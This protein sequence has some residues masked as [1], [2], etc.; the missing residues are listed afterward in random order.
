MPQVPITMPQLGESMAEAT[1]V[2]IKV[3][4]GDK[5][6]ADQEIIEVETDKA[7]MGVTTPCAGEISKIEAEVKKVYPVGA[8]L[9]YVEASEAD[10][11]RFKKAEPPQGDVAQEVPGRE[12]E[13]TKAGV[14]A[15]GSHFQIDEKELAAVPTGSHFQ[16]D[17]AGVLPVP[18]GAKGA[19]Y[20]SPRVR[21]RM[22]ELGLTN[23]DL[24]S[25]AGSGNAGRV[26]I[27]DL[28]SFLG[29]LE[30]QKVEEASAI[31]TGVANAMRRSWS[32]PLSTIG[33]SVCLDPVLEDR[34][35][36]DPKPGPALY[37]A[38][39]LAVALA[40][41]PGAASRLIGSRVA[42]S[43]S[44]DIGVAVE[45]QD[46]IMV[47]VIREMDKKSLGDLAK[48]YG[49]LVALARQRRISPDMQ[50]GGIATV[51]N[52]GSFGI[53]WGT[54]IPLP[55]QTLLLG[56]GAGKKQPVWD[57][58]KNQF[59]PRTEAQLTLSFDH[60]SLDGGGGGRLLQRVIELLGTPEKL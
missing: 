51:S 52:F 59:I 49:E 17:Q 43:P 28:E 35:K 18:A 23:A 19:G 37:A 22:T 56:L 15:N 44:I 26:T 3:N 10:A 14:A 40:E 50:A 5:V 2:A 25:I 27:K 34:K 7:V 21:A 47:P 41:N 60:R 29:G 24:A 16:V 20:F 48:S 39:A 30:K 38:R 31:R 33:S 42:Q 9:G 58:T 36:R 57:E 12:E 6:A 46:G 53:E 8:I 32:R 11:A 13:A 55:D 54:P 45:A 4:P 1:I